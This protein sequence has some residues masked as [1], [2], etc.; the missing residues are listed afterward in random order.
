VI[1]RQQSLTIFGYCGNELMLPDGAEKPQRDRLG[2]TI[3]TARPDVT[4]DFE[5]AFR[6]LAPHDEDEGSFE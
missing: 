5:Y 4:L 1:I 2:I 3:G 6:Q